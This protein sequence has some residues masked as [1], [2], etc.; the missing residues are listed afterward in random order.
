MA[1]SLLPAGKK[2]TKSASIGAKFFCCNHFHSGKGE[3]AI[4]PNE[5][6]TPI[7]EGGERREGGGKR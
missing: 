5:P 6:T 3:G 1:W 2:G 4:L 7:R